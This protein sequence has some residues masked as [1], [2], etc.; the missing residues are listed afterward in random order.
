MANWIIQLK[1]EVAGKVALPDNMVF[2]LFMY[3]DFHKAYTRK[4][5]QQNINTTASVCYNK[6]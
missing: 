2:E 1:G 6:I 5:I 3:R 4:N